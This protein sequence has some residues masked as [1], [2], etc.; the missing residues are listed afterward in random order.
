MDGNFDEDKSYLFT[1]ST[2]G[3]K[4]VDA[5]ETLPILTIRLAPSV[6]Y[7]IPA[8]FGVRNL[9]NRSQLILKQLGIIT[10]GQFIVTARINSKSSYFETDSNW[11]GAGNGSLAQY[12]DHTLDLADTPVTDGDVVAQFLTDE[13]TNR[14][15]ASYFD[16]QDV[17]PL[18]NSI[19]G[20]PNTFPDGPDTLVI[21]A[22]NTG[23]SAAS[24]GASVNW[25]E[26]QG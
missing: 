6:D 21:F 13:G 17:R 1:A 22:T 11:T 19:L 10:D 5:G 18:G 9:I 24:I 4:S 16:I 20:G 3:T 25:T 8:F 14:F 26:S 12:V 23:G 15:A 7:G 2:A